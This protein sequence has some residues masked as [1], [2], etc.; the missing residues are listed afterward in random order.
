MNWLQRLLYRDRLEEELDTELRFHVERLVAEYIAAGLTEVEARR[1]ALREFGAV[2]F[3][4]DDCRRMR[5]TEWLLDLLSD[6]RVGAR[7]FAKERG[8]ALVAVAALGLGLGVNT[9]FFS[10]VDASCLS[11]LP[12]PNASNLVDVSV[13][14]DVGTPRPFSPAQVRAMA[15]LPFIDHVGFYVTKPGA[16]RTSDSVAQRSTVAYV[17][18]EALSLIG[19]TPSRGRTFRPEE[20]RDAYGRIVLVSAELSNELFGDESAAIGQDIVLDGVS[21]AVIGVLPK[22]A[23]FP[24]NADV[25]KPLSSLGLAENAPQLTL[26][27]RLKTGAGALDSAASQIERVLRASRAIESDRQRVVV[28]PLN[29]RYRGRATDPVWVAFMAAGAL[30]VLIACSNVGNLLLARGVRRSTEIATRLSLG[31]TRARIVRQLLAETFVLVAAACA[32]AVLVSWTGLRALTATIPPG[33][34]PYWMHYELSWR[35]LSVLLGVA[36]VTIVLSGLAPAVHLVRLP[37]GPFNGRTMSHSNTISRWS[38]AFLIVQLSVSVLLLCAVGITVQVYQS[39]TTGGVP[40]RLAEILSAEISLSA[41]RLSTAQKRERFLKDLRTQL[42][43]AGQVTAVSF[44]D[45]LPGTRGT[46]RTVAAG[47]ITGGALVMAMTVD[48]RYFVTLGVPLLSG[49]AFSESDSDVTG[50]SVVVND[51]FARLF[52]GDVSIVGQQIQF[53]SSVPAQ[54]SRDSRIIVGVVASFR[55]EAPFSGPPIVYIPRALGASERS[56]LLMRG[57][58]SPQELAPVLRKAVVRVDPDVPLSDVLPL[59]DA[60]WQ[61]RW[62]GRVSQALITSIAAV[63]F[64]LA[65]V[66]VAAL[67]AHRIATRARELSIRVALGATPRQLQWTV[68]GPIVIQLAVGLTCGGLLAKAWQRAFGSPIGASDDLLLVSILVAVAALVFSAWPAR[69]VA[70]ADPLEALRAER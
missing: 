29:D 10:I 1:R 2:E 6:C 56:I 41:P 8:F 14:D 34:L 36:V 24:D 68:L 58:V 17:S 48:S 57:L 50:S 16:V 59:T 28:I 70:H 52:F 9:V 60:T 4:K 65:L 21:A 27:A 33:A 67:T 30:V 31:A 54:G 32:A 3:V 62:N 18:K 47:S 5:R 43:A 13:R 7:I 38:S 22:L 39:L 64:C 11:G 45:V 46:P 19:E 63:G 25:W 37:R 49:R 44:T 15:D 20:Y 42:T 26:F 61:A 12:Y 66:G 51:R 40:A 35:A 69:R 55:G 23:R 53:T